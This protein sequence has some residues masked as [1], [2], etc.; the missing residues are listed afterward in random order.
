M[1]SKGERVLSEAW[2]HDKCNPGLSNW[3]QSVSSPLLHDLGSAGDG[4]FSTEQ[5]H[6]LL[7]T[8]WGRQS[9]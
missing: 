7:G 6:R 8:S 5:M 2:L 1:L 9:V 3:K 4:M